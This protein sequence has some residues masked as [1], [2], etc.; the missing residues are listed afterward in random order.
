MDSFAGNPFAVLTFIVAPAILT[1][2]SS[3]MALTTSN[4]F[5]RAVDRVR[6]LSDELEG[7][8]ELP[9]TTSDLRRRQLGAARRRAQL[10]VRAM[11][12]FHLSVGAFAAASLT[13]LFGSAFVLVGHDLARTVA[14][15]VALSCGVVGVAGLVGGSALLVLETRLT[16]AVLSDETNFARHITDR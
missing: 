8:T 12:A 13:S 16:L 4:R 15:V 14:M 2:A 6:G 10:L 9:P 5:A 3:V 1:N 11:T 7:G